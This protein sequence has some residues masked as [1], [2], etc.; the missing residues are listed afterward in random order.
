MSGPIGKPV[1]VLGYPRR[2][3]NPPKSCVEFR[4]ILLILE[5]MLAKLPAE[6]KRLIYSARESY[7]DYG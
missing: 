2:S 1:N 4:P 7:F 5:L 3:P 6:S